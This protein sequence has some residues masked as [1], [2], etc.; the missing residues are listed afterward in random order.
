MT[1]NYEWQWAIEVRAEEFFR[2][3]YPSGS[4]GRCLFTV[5]AKPPQPG[6]R[7]LSPIGKIGIAGGIGPR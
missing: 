5:Q 3:D 2:R 7:S 1:E 6:W 4:F